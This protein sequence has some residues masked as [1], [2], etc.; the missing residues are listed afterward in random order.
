MR[1]HQ[2]GSH[3][4]EALMVSKLRRQKLSERKHENAHTLPVQMQHGST[5]RVYGLVRST[6]R[7]C[8]FVLDQKIGR[9]RCRRADS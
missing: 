9:R 3:K 5:Q 8:M 2:A 7:L 6:H 1:A 4:R